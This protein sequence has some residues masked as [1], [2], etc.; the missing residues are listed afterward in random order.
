[1]TRARWWMRIVGGF[2]VVLAAF[3]LVILMGPDQSM[4]ADT[5]PYAATPDTTAAFA[6]AWLVFVLELLAIGIV[7][8]AASRRP[9]ENRILFPLV[10]V[11][12]LLRGILAD[13]IWIGRGYSAAS[14]LTFIGI[15]VAV[16][17]SGWI[18][19]RSFPTRG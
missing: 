8:I 13:A 16:I 18:I 14:Y 19:W 2:Y 9:A 5:L 10:I 7:L 3:N 17:V 15:H 4:L 12:E 11:A 6:D 1:M